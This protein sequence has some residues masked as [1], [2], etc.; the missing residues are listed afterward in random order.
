M[1]KETLRPLIDFESELIS[2]SKINGRSKIARRFGRLSLAGE[3]L[4]EF[5]ICLE[6]RA[7]FA[8]CGGSHSNLYRHL[9]LHEKDGKSK[10]I[11]NQVML[12]PDKCESKIKTRRKKRDSSGF[13]KNGRKHH[14]P[15]KHRKSHQ[16]HYKY[17]DL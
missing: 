10:K 17:L 15:G 13:R 1:N 11:I 4:S 14:H 8:N 5:F 6:C 12:S 16:W 2:L 3:P 7:L 9:E